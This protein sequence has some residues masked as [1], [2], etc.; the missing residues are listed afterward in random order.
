MADQ[1]VAQFWRLEDAELTAQAREHRVLPPFEVLEVGPDR[2]ALGVEACRSGDA[3]LEA[4]GRRR[5]PLDAAAIAQCRRLLE[6]DEIERARGLLL[7]KAT[8]RLH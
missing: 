6:L 5:Q 7:R 2:L 1:P 3:L 4:R 8:E